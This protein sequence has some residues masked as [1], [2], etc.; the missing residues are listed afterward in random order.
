MLT[1]CILNEFGSDH[2]QVPT[3]SDTVVN[4]GRQGSARLKCLDP[5]QCTKWC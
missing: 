3:V 4:S 1:L 5:S 2:E